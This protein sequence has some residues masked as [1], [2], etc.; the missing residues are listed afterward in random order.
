MSGEL[1][2]KIGVISGSEIEKAKALQLKEGGSLLEC[3]VRVGAVQEEAFVGS[4]AAHLR[5][6][7]VDAARLGNIPA[8][9]L[10]LVPAEMAVEFRALPIAVDGDGT[11]MLAMS[12]PTDE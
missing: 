1:L 12:D 7:R 2:Q 5:I 4:L 6:P 3:L 10:G 9:V 11:L 8:S